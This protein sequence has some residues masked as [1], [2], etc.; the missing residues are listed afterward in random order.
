MS[1]TLT[2]ERSEIKVGRRLIYVGARP[3]TSFLGG[4]AERDGAGFVVTDDPSP[5]KR[6]GCTWQAT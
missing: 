1:D 2:G 4:L 3:A 6:R 5:Q